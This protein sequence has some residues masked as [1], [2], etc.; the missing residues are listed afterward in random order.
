MVENVGSQERR[1]DYYSIIYDGCFDVSLS[2]V[3]MMCVPR[4]GSDRTGL[5]ME[6]IIF[7]RTRRPHELSLLLMDVME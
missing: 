7:V 2:I 5:G 6:V 3:H 1:L 4:L